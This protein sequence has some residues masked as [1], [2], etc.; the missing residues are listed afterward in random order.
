MNFEE[1]LK[2]VGEITEIYDL[3]LQTST[4]DGR[5]NA[6]QDWLKDNRK[7]KKRIEA[8]ALD[9]PEDAYE[10]LKAFIADQSKIPIIVLNKLI[11]IQ[12]ATQAHA[13]LATIQQL[14]RERAELKPKRRKVIKH[15][16]KKSN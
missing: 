9:T 10:S 5:W 11:T 14:Y 1:A 16:G 6:L 8:W 4:P 7:W 15:A 3:I 13:T 2:T 12:M